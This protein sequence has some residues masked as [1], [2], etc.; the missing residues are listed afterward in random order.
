MPHYLQVVASTHSTAP[1]NTNAATDNE[2]RL[3]ASVRDAARHPREMESPTRVLLVVGNLPEETVSDMLGWLD[4]SHVQYD[5]CATRPCCRH[6]TSRADHPEGAFAHAHGRAFDR[7]EWVRAVIESHYDVVL[8]DVNTTGLEVATKQIF[9]LEQASCVFDR[10]AHTPTVGLCAAPGRVLAPAFGA[11]AGID[12]YLEPLT[13]G[14]VLAKVREWM[15]RARDRPFWVV[16]L[17]RTYQ[18]VGG[19]L[20]TMCATVDEFVHEGTSQKR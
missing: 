10:I 17:D 11:H 14:E 19:D 9:E 6:A 7:F 20:A 8:V 15:V 16:D 12:D 4:E 18:Y 13:A 2:R 3:E 1:M 5:Q